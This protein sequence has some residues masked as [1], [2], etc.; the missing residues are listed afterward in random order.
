MEAYL[1]QYFG[2]SR[3]RQGQKE[4]IESVLSKQ[5]VFAVLP[6]GTGKSICYQ[7][8]AMM[9][10]GAVVV[11][12]PLLSLMTDQ[13]K[14]LKSQGIKR[15]VALNSMLTP[16]ERDSHLANLHHYKLIYMS[17]EMLQSKRM[18]RR[19]QQLTISLFVI[20][21]AHCI[22]QWGHEF[23]PDYLRLKQIHQLLDSPPLLAL[24]ATA[25]P[26]VQDDIIEALALEKLRKFVYPMD[27]P[28]IALVVEQ[29][30]TIREKEERLIRLM[31]QYHI[32]TLIYFSS[33]KETSRMAALLQEQIPNRRIAFY[34]GGLDHQD[35][36]LIQQ[37]F[38]Q[39]QL[40]VVCCTNAFGM[41]IN[42]KDI[43]FVIHY[44]APS[45][46][47]AFIQEIGRSGRNGQES[48]SLVF[49]HESDRIIPQ[50]L[51]ESELPTGEWVQ[52][53]LNCLY[54]EDYSYEQLKEICLLTADGNEVY[55]RFLQFQ[56]ERLGVL[57]ENTFYVQQMPQNKVQQ[58]IEQLIAKRLQYKTA[59]LEEM[60]E[61]LYTNSCRRQQLFKPFQETLQPSAYMCC[62]HCDF[63][64]TDW[65][66]SP[67][68]Q[69][70][71]EQDW[72]Q[73]LMRI[74]YQGDTN[75]K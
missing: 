57:Q 34:H 67:H 16:R 64:W 48:V 73:T 36:L 42:K 25:T 6:T 35:R 74:L 72:L 68:E 13:V 4:I 56:L 44:H 59:K 53:A 60:L 22:S 7:L 71:Q 27:K 65:Q 38:M 52:F 32:P 26:E 31:E 58:Q 47:E 43:Q 37:Q 55:W 45:Q 19:L 41:G 9:L 15:V 24:T 54:Q 33:R 14:Q 21:E 49:F 66:P 12:S 63:S 1:K 50:R 3:F 28:N 61:W 20:D 10:P 70:A 40:E 51:L 11:I 75:E 17:P 30:D 18:I 2:F 29:V 46:I 23:R 5:H 69:T 8:P 39:N 62:D